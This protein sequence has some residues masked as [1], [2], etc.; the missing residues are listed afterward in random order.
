MFY[1]KWLDPWL[2][3]DILNWDKEVYDWKWEK[4]DIKVNNTYYKLKLNQSKKYMKLWREPKV[5]KHIMDKVGNYT[6]Y[7]YVLP[8]F[9]DYDNVINFRRFNSLYKMTG[10]QIKRFRDPLIECWL[11]KKI[12]WYYYLSPL[13]WIRGDEIP[14]ELLRMFWDTYKDF[15]VDLTYNK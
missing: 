5:K 8:D 11:I 10:S 3:R 7:L 2:I 12:D 9:I 13:V 4:V 15:W 14:Q 6:K 1:K